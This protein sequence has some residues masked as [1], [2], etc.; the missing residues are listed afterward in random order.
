MTDKQNTSA[1]VQELSISLVAIRMGIQILIDRH[2]VAA[3]DKELIALKGLIE[4]AY[5]TTG[6]LITATIA[7]GPVIE[8]PPASGGASARRIKRI[9]RLNFVCRR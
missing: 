3:L 5:T 9:Q 1:L 2:D 6:S 8:L 4:D 7:P